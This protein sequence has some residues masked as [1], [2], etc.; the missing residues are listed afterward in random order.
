MM[1]AA[2]EQIVTANAADADDAQCLGSARLQL[3]QLMLVMRSAWDQI[4]ADPADDDFDVL[5]ME[6]DRSYLTQLM[7][8]GASD[9]IARS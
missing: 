2:S 1:C 8:R 3:V 7:M 5:S 9:Q 6:S 4:A